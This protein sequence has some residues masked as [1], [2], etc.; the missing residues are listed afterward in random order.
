VSGVIV[1]EKLE[2]IRVP[3]EEVDDLWPLIEPLVAK[4]LKRACGRVSLASLREGAMA[5]HYGIFL[6]GGP[7][8]GVVAV[9]AT[10]ILVFPAK[11][12][13]SV[14]LYSGERRQAM[15][16]WPKV[17]EHA[18]EMGC[19]EVQIAGPKAWGKLFPDFRAEFI[20]YT[21]EV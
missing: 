1:S 19:S 5:G 21:K 18:R 12:V 20:V 16:L 9:A 13:L 3:P 10:E 2:L 4:S 14:F 11:R 6:V 8:Y 17:Y 7:G 15:H